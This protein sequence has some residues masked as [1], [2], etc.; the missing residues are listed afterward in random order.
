[1]LV[2]EQRNRSMEENRQH[3]NKL[4]IWSTDLRQRSKGNTTEQIKSLQQMMLEQLNFC[5]K[6]LKNV[7]T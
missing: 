1:M 5:I 6:I 7:K 3:R 2:R 4:T